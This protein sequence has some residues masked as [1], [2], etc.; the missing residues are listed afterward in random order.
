MLWSTR[1]RLFFTCFSHN[2]ME[3]FGCGVLHAHGHQ[4]N[5]MH[6]YTRAHTHKH[7]TFL[8]GNVH[9]CTQPQGRWCRGGWGQLSASFTPPALTHRGTNTCWGVSWA[10]V[11]R[12]SGCHPAAPHDNSKTNLPPKLYIL[13]H[14]LHFEYNDDNSN[15]EMAIA[16]LLFMTFKG[17][18]AA[19]LHPFTL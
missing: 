2:M 13:Q 14:P 16:F 6:I 18:Q 8:R 17:A 5:Y 11:A 4:H 1:S 15:T 3:W 10:S 7:I 9:Q 12:S 19:L